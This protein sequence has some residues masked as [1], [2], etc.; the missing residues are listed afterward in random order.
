MK[1]GKNGFTVLELLIVIAILLIGASIAIPSIL[2]MGKRD[3]I[4]SDAR[5]LK[6]IF[7]RTRMEAVKL[8]RSV[9]VAFNCGGNDYIAFIDTDHSCEYDLGDEVLYRQNLSYC[10]FDNSKAGGD[11]LSFIANDNGLPALRWDSKGIPNRNGAG[12]GAGTA[13]LMGEEAHYKVIVSK[14]GN[15][16]ITTY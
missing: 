15:I 6:N 7:F 14:T 2:E 8:N 10:S 12:F 16:R 13:Y 5:D 9:T 11:G 3:G 1:L 4:R